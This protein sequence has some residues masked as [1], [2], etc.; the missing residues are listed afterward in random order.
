MTLKIDMHQHS[1]DYE[2]KPCETFQSSLSDYA[3]D[4]GNWVSPVA[5][6]SA[7]R[8]ADVETGRSP[9][10]DAVNKSFTNRLSLRE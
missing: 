5:T 4:G 10:H 2:L 9:T 1:C 6:L 3:L 7:G 8:F